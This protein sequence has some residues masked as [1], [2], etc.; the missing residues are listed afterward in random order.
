MV[1]SLLVYNAIRPGIE[2]PSLSL[3]TDIVGIGDEG[4][5]RKYAPPRVLVKARDWFGVLWRNTFNPSLHNFV[6]GINRSSCSFWLKLAA[7][8]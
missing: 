1:S 2:Q 6:S 7:E 5:A 3:C 4:V 8:A